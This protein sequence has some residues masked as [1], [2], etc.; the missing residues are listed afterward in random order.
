MD[1][2]NLDGIHNREQALKAYANI[3]KDKEYSDLMKVMRD[4]KWVL[5]N[6]FPQKVANA[7]KALDLAIKYTNSRGFRSPGYSGIP[8]EPDI[9]IQEKVWG[10]IYTAKL[11]MAGP[12][13]LLWFW[14]E[15]KFLMQIS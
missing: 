12:L 11:E 4:K 3:S 6:Y 14:M 10:R 13:G 5:E 7:V 2:H 8:V 1:K 15:Q 9:Y